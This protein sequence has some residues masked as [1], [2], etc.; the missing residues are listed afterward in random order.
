MKVVILAGGYGTRLSELTHEI[1]KPM[2]EIGGYPIIWHIMNIYATQGFNDFIVA[3]GYKGSKIRDFFLNYYHNNSDLS[4][5]LNDGS[6]KIHTNNS[7]NWK[8]TLVDT[9]VNTMTGGRLKRLSHFLD[10]QFMVTYGDGVS[11]IDLNSLIKEHNNSR[12]MAT[13]TAVHPTSKYGKLEFGEDGKVENFIEKPEFGGDWINGGFMVMEPDFLKLINDD[14]T[15]LEQEPLKN[16]AKLNSLAAYKHYGFWHCMD[17][18]RDKND[19]EA[20]WKNDEAR[21]KIW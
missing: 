21:W 20:L 2:V 10:D 4:I 6:M 18:L 16:A 8:V 1:P 19:L 7:L 17:T 5:D 3:L 13:L 15:V 9:G 11:D 12:N 14:K